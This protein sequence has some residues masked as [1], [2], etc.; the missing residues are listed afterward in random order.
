MLHAT[1]GHVFPI[2]VAPPLSL[3]AR[4][5]LFAVVVL[6]LARMTSAPPPLPT[7]PAIRGTVHHPAFLVRRI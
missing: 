1:R 4:A 7:L 5:T 2:A 6:A 3:L